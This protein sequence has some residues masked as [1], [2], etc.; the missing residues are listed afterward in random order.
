MKL[1]DLLSAQA[2]LVPCSC[3]A[4][5]NRTLPSARPHCPLRS[6][7]APPLPRGACLETAL[8]GRCR[9]RRV[10]VGG[11]VSQGSSEEFTAPPWR[12]ENPRVKVAGVRCEG[13]LTVEWTWRSWGR[14]RPALRA[15]VFTILPLEHQARARPQQRAVCELGSC[16]PRRGAVHADARMQPCER[17]AG[18]PG[19][20]GRQSYEQDTHGT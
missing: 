11:G 8:S 19:G 14:R 13:W 5:S 12:E 4:I 16:P 18:A 1:S 15:R 2:W 10:I 3:R 7:A 17:L 6:C 20:D 9:L